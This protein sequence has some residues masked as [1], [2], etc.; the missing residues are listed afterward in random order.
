[1]SSEGTAELAKEPGEALPTLHHPPDGEQGRRSSSL[2][3]SF[4]CALEPFN[5]SFNSPVLGACCR[6]GKRFIIDGVTLCH[7]PSPSQETSVLHVG[8]LRCCHTEF[9]AVPA[10][11]WAG[12]GPALRPHTLP[13]GWK[14]QRL[15]WSAAFQASFHRFPSAAPILRSVTKVLGTC[16]GSTVPT[17]TVPFQQHPCTLSGKSPLYQ[18]PSPPNSAS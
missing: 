16:D 12:V 4:S 9:T 13:S 17:L 15:H 11:P 5:V 2:L 10:R 3:T 8:S 14:M 6:R 18:L 1:M 7:G